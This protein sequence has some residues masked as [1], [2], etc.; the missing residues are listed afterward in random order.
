MEMKN[1]IKD[2][3]KLK[4]L[5]FS[6]PFLSLNSSSVVQPLA[7]VQMKD[8]KNVAKVIVK[9]HFRYPHKVQ[10]NA[11]PQHIKQEKTI[12]RRITVDLRSVLKEAIELCEEDVSDTENE[13]NSATAL[14]D[15]GLNTEPNSYSTLS[16]QNFQSEIISSST[17]QILEQG[18]NRRYISV[19]E[20]PPIQKTIGLSI[21]TLQNCER[22]EEKSK[23]AQKGQTRV[24]LVEITNTGT[25]TFDKKE[26]FTVTP[27]VSFPKIILQELPSQ[28]MSKEKKQSLNENASW[29]GLEKM[30]L[31]ISEL[32]RVI[33]E[34]ANSEQHTLIAKVLYSL[35]EKQEKDTLQHVGVLGRIYNE[36]SQKIPQIPGGGG[37]IR[38]TWIKR[39]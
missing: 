13:S 24:N 5:T 25:L 34:Q 10:Y 22:H 18:L 36:T 19:E 6:K 9:D 35:R 7:G 37:E 27:P 29:L 12:V 1:Y 2:H 32:V 14:L 28:K 39:S 4:Q 26:Q 23:P 33:K 16:E 8:Y 15:Q 21:P 3:R 30:Q 31:P 17:S 11:A 20:K 38:L